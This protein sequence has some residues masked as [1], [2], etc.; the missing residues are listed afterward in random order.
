MGLDGVRTIK[1]VCLRLLPFL[2]IWRRVTDFMVRKIVYF[3]DS[4]GQ[5]TWA[6]DFELESGDILNRRVLVD[7][8]GSEGEPDGLVV[9]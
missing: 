5:K 2:F 6:Y 9:E 8:T 4:I 1:P 7:F 3:N